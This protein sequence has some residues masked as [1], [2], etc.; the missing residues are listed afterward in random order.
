[1]CTICHTKHIIIDMNT[2]LQFEGIRRIFTRIRV[3]IDRQTSRMH[4][5]KIEIL[6][7]LTFSLIC[8]IFKRK[9]AFGR[10]NDVC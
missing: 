9:Y 3:C 4:K 8:T 2:T 10:I 6:C 1:M 5:Q 7:I